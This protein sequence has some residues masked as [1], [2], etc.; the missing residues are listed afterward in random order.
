MEMIEEKHGYAW[1]GNQVM[2]HTQAFGATDLAA[3]ITGA[4]H[5]RYM[6]KCMGVDYENFH[7]QDEPEIEERPPSWNPGFN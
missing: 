1:P 5:F 6:L 7:L 2:A 3:K 4:V